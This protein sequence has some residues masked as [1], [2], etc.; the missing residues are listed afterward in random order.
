MSWN[1]PKDKEVLNWERLKK[2]MLLDSEFTHLGLP[3]FHEKPTVLASLCHTLVLSI[4][5]STQD[6]SQSKRTKRPHGHLHPWGP[7]F[8]RQ[9]ATETWELSYRT[10]A[11]L[12]QMTCHL[13]DW[14]HRRMTLL[15]GK[16]SWDGLF[17]LLTMG[18]SHC[19]GWRVLQ[20]IKRVCP[21]KVLFPHYRP[22]WKPF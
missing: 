11:P 14:N 7:V 4:M 21:I 18:E 12:R 1:Y 17:F 15:Q 9:K 19:W 8:Q 16:V 22:G 13:H 5:S 20:A 10:S 6:D 3:T 2:K